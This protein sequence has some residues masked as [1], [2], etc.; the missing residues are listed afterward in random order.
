MIHSA[1]ESAAAPAGHP[2]FERPSDG[3]PHARLVDELVIHEGLVPFRTLCERAIAPSTRYLV[4]D[5]DR[6]LHLGHN[7][8]ELLGW[9]LNALASYGEEFLGAIDEERGPGRF[10]FDTQ[11]PLAMLRYFAR[12]ARLWAYPGLL[13]L[14]AVK[15][16]TRSAKVRPWLYRRFGLNTVEVVQDVPRTAVMHQLAEVPIATLR[17][18]ALRIWRRYVEDQVIGADD[19]RWLRRRCPGIR[20]ILSSASPQ[21]VV[22][23]AA[24][25]LGIDDVFYTVIE[26]RDGFFSSPHVIDRRFLRGQ[27]PQRISPP[28][29]ACTNSGA[30]KMARLVARYPDFA[31]PDVPTVG[32]TDTS[33][34]EDHAWTDYCDTVVDINSG[35]PFSP[36]IARS[37]PLR[38]IHSAQVMTRA[39][40]DDPARPTRRSA[41]QVHPAGNG[42]RHWGTDELAAELADKLAAVESLATCYRE[43]AQSLQAARHRLRR[44]I[45]DRVT[46][47]ERDVQAFDDGSLLARPRLLQQLRRDLRVQRAAERELVRLERP[48]SRLTCSLEELLAASRSTLER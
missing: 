45:S 22:E 24:E 7:L 28:S 46:V 5:L 10:V 17:T 1:T 3:P 33:Y 34:G 20:I 16:G 18:L 32:V 9:E 41:G 30:T 14:F 37:S 40:I 39:E 19:I 21:P 12:G 31:S 8:G 11:R 35:A 36:I 29:Q 42:E 2:I 38:A 25:Q 15:L 6:T 26:A 48:L 44:G 23:V 13:Y 43:E 47:I 27:D 4:F